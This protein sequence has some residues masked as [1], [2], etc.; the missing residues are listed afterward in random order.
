MVPRTADYGD[1]ALIWAVKLGHAR[2]A[3]L[4][5]ARGA[6]GTLK[7]RAGRDALRHVRDL[8]RREIEL[9]LRTGRP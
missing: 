7:D 4:L 5:I 9:F 1:T 3:E 6:D 8:G 2:I